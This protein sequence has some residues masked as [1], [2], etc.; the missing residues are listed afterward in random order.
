[1]NSFKFFHAAL[2]TIPSLSN[3][4]N[5]LNNQEIFDPVLTN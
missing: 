3:P 5:L 2:T 1:M 4:N